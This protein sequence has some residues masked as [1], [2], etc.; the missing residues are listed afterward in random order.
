L[1]LWHLEP[2]CKPVSKR[3]NFTREH[4]RRVR[5]P[6]VNFMLDFFAQK[7][8]VDVSEQWYQLFYGRIWKGS[9]RRSAQKIGPLSG[10]ISSN[11]D[12]PNIT[13]A[14]FLT[15]FRACGCDWIFSRSAVDPSKDLVVSNFLD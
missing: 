7:A 12:V 13:C 8:G 9:V 2:L 5:S 1:K 6:I 3:I 10:P 4:S 15:V 14:V 11:S